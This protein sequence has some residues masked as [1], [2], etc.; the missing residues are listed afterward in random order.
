VYAG[1]YQFRSLTLHGAGGALLWGHWEA[2]TLRQWS[3]SKQGPTWRL[4][5]TIERIDAIRSRQRPLLFS[6]PRS[7]PKGYWAWGV[8]SIT[9]SMGGQYLEATLGPPEH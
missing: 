9:V 7:R 4:V 5:A 2:I 8:E 1:Q 3:I 6:A